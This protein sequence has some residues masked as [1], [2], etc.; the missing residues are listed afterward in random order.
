[1]IFILDFDVPDDE[2]YTVLVTQNI[3]KALDCIINSEAN[4]IK[5]WKDEELI[6]DWYF[7]SIGDYETKDE[8]LEDMKRQ[9]TAFTTRLE[10]LNE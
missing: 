3:D 4:S 9:F 5:V 6:E 2:W 1:M 7:G 8:Y 10:E